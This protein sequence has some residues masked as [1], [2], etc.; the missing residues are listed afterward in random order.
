MVQNS[1]QPSDLNRSE[2]TLL[3]FNHPEMAALI[4]QRGWREQSE[5]ER[6]GSIYD[7]VRNEIAFGYNQSD[8]IPAS[9]VL[10]DRYGQC[11]TKATLLMA[12][13]RGA[14][15]P[16]RLHGFTIHKSLQR[17]VVPEFFYGIAPHDILH[18]WVE[19]YYDNRWINLEGFIL[20]KVYLGRLQDVYGA[21]GSLCGFG[22]GSD[23]I[24]APQVDW[25]GKDTYIQKTGINND[26]GLYNSPDLF[27]AKYQQNMSFIKKKIYQHMIRHIMNRRVDRIRRG[28]FPTVPE[29]NKPKAPNAS[30]TVGDPS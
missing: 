2:T 1:D 4:E 10:K 13:F 19:I 14:D 20:D 23:N 8:D 22:A 12:L 7:F 5:Y 21:K 27:Y 9:K 17:G 26:L 24:S 3:N 11:N 6:I 18:S 25:Q 28:W 16:C 30:H 29:S 15:I